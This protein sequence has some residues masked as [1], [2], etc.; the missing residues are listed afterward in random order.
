[1]RLAGR[2][3]RTRDRQFAAVWSNLHRF[4]QVGTANLVRRTLAHLA[5]E[6]HPCKTLVVAEMPRL[7][8]F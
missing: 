8:T 3:L 4:Y 2:R 1:M 6:W 5:Q 7:A